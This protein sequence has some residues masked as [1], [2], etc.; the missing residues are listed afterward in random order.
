MAV[1]NARAVKTPYEIECIRRA[2]QQLDTMFL[3]I[4]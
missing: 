4:P 1:R 2:A 3:D